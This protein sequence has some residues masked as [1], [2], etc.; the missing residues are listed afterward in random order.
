MA[1]AFE[2]DLAKRIKPL[3]VRLKKLEDQVYLVVVDSVSRSKLATQYWNRR[4]REINALY[5]RMNESFSAW[6][7]QEIPSSYRRSLRLIR[8]RIKGLQ[9]VVAK[10]SLAELVGTTASSQI[11]SGL[12]TSAVESY[13]SASAAGRA[14]LRNLFIRTQQTL[15]N[16]GLVNVAVGTGFEMGNLRQAKSLLSA[17][18][19][20]RD[21]ETV[22]NRQFI[23]AGSK[24]FKPSYYAEMVART[25]FHQAQSQ[26]AVMQSINHGTD[27]IEVSSHNTTTRICIPFEG[28]IYSLSGTHKRYPPVTDLSPFHPN[29]LHLTFP[30]FE[31]S[32]AA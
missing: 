10:K 13:I 2:T 8:R 18:F 14:S 1:N 11:V 30:W 31:S 29:C 24:Q 27:L 5:V 23:R 4:K 6:A 16:E 3:L 22:G 25:K 17:I 28:N 20:S 12:Y 26:A 9:G 7:K 19:Q 15:V 21:W 32:L